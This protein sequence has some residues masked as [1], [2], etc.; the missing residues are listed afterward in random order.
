[1][2]LVAA[3]CSAKS[4][5]REVRV[6]A[7]SDL[8]KAFEEVGKEF[9]ARTGITPK[10]T[11][12]SSGL[13]AKQIE[14]G[15]EYFLFAA[16]NKRFAQHPVTAGRCDAASAKLYARGRVVVWTPSGIAAPAKLEDLTHERFKRIA[17]ANPDHAPYGAAAKQALE[18][19]GLWAQLEDRVVLGDNVQSTMLY[20]RDR[21]AEAAIVALSLALVTD[22]GA[23]LPI[24]QSLHDP[25][26]QQLV[27]CGSGEEAAAARKLAEFIGSREG[28]EIMTR[29]GFLLPDEQMPNVTGRPAE[30]A[31]GQN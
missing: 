29:Y 11:F 10:F 14:Q 7:A 25:L 16:A 12:G 22:G 24:D 26:D 18:K 30:A 31:R 20:A 19:L 9:K 5:G 23:F 6:A 15:A 3:A 2:L 17:I 4:N 8:A 1:M 28:R 27:V 21:N 13:L